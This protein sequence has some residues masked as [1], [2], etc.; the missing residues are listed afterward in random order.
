MTHKGCNN[1]IFDGNGNSFGAL[2]SSGDE[3]AKAIAVAITGNTY[4]RRD[5]YEMKKAQN[6]GKNPVTINLIDEGFHFV[7]F[8][9]TQVSWFT[10]L[11]HTNPPNPL[12]P[13]QQ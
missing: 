6:R 12:L 8:T 10:L 5:F 9:P 4:L 1:Q 7:K 2:V 13:Q 11:F 3:G